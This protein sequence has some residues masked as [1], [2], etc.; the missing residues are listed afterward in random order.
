[1]EVVENLSD[2]FHRISIVQW[3]RPDQTESNPLFDQQMMAVPAGE[4]LDQGAMKAKSLDVSALKCADSGLKT[5]EP[6]ISIHI[7]SLPHPTGISVFESRGSGRWPYSFALY[8]VVRNLSPMVL[9]Q[10]LKKVTLF[11]L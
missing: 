8:Y 11:R 1:V 3:P 2:F 5:E 9:A 6:E 4:E 7:E 10:G